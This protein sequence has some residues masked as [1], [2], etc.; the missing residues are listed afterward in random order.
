MNPEWL[1]Y[2]HLSRVPGPNRPESAHV[3]V[4]ERSL[5]ECDVCL[6]WWR[7]VLTAARDGRIAIPSETEQTELPI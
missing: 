2:E 4:C 7:E 5:S 1:N 6:T 3:N